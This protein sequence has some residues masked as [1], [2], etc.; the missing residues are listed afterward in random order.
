MSRTL[1]RYFTEREARERELRRFRRA[2]EA[3]GHAVF[4]T[5]TD[6]TIEYANPAFEEITGYDHEEVIGSTPS[7][8]NSGEMSD[9]YFAELWDTILSGEEWAE[10][11]V[12][13][14][15]DGSLYHAHQTIAPIADDG[16]I[17]TFVA[18]Q[19]DITERKER[20]RQ[21]RVLSRVLRHNLRNDMSVIR[22]WA[23]SIRAK[24][25]DEIAMDA[26]RIVEKSDALLDATDKQRALAEVL[27]SDPEQTDLDVSTAVGRMAAAVAEDYPAATIEVDAPDS[28]VA[29]ATPQLDQAIEELL[30]NA[31]LHSDRETPEIEVSVA[32]A[33]DR[34]EIEIADDGPRI[35][36][37]ERKVLVGGETVG[38]LYHGSGLGL[39]L[40]YWIV[41]SSGGSLSFHENEPRGNVVRITLGR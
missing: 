3:A 21:L 18:I 2:V 30:V 5:D 37:M 33:D 22:G 9:A 16:D 15:A 7:I 19:T 17:E 24:T 20:E 26:D 10:E 31:T 38:P 41:T 32:A 39:W 11:V 25:D 4:L 14:R 1:D 13:R 28:A 36:E 27:L 23:E 8:L 6:G 29:R 40:V 12:N 35:P 34:V